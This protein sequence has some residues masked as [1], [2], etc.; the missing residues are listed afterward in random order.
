[1]RDELDDVAA[2]S[3]VALVFDDAH[4]PA[5]NQQ[6][7]TGALERVDKGPGPDRGFRALFPQRGD[8][9]VD[10][11]HPR[12]HGDGEPGD[13]L[14][15]L[16]GVFAHADGKLD[17]FARCG[18]VGSPDQFAGFG[19]DFGSRRALRQGVHERQSRLVG[20][21]GPD[22]DPQGLSI[23]DR[24]I[25]GELDRWLAVLFEDLNAIGVSTA[26]LLG[27]LDRYACGDLK[28]A[29]AV[30]FLGSPREFP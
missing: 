10:G 18:R 15:A 5:V 26:L 4:L 23:R 9:P 21:G 14:K 27:S 25:G 8:E 30:L 1:M 6:G 3:F 28:I 16:W 12:H 11:P 2:G 24:D 19:V 7:Q 29:R 13:G 22:H 20:I 17:I